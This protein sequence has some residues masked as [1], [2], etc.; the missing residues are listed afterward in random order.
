MKIIKGLFTGVLA[1]SLLT[2]CSESASEK[3]EREEQEA[4]SA[5]LK[6]V[7][8]NTFPDEKDKCMVSV[9]ANTK[10]ISD[11][12]ERMKE[13]YLDN[14]KNGDCTT[15]YVIVGDE[16]DMNDQPKKKLGFIRIAFNEMAAKR[17]GI[18]WK[19]YYKASWDAK[20]FNN[21]VVK[22]EEPILNNDKVEL[23]LQ[24]TPDKP[25]K[26][27]RDSLLV[28]G[29][30]NPK[31]TATVN[32]EDVTKTMKNGY[33]FK[34]VPLKV[35]DNTIVIKAMLKGKEKTIKLNVHRNTKEEDNK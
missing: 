4:I 22:K 30:T 7:S 23:S 31:A 34:D 28:S 8:Y 1:L 6:K 11:L 32:G 9:Q 3:K 20:K 33:F 15:M 12:A 35:G 19:D 14:G 16:F 29:V 24:Y 13:D 5:R 2:A 17:W 27:H 25:F 26:N 18:P 21:P 10:D